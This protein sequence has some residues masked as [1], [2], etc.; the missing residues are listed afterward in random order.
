MKLQ[1]DEDNPKRWIVKDDRDVFIGAIDQI[2]HEEWTATHVAGKKLTRVPFGPH[3]T[4]EAAFEAFKTRLETGPALDKK[5]PKCG[6]T[7]KHTGSTPGG[8]YKP[9]DKF[10]TSGGPHHY[11]CPNGHGH[12]MYSGGKLIEV[13]S[14]TVT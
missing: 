14:S 11:E 13:G 12:F 1:V 5:C 10:K 2:G 3:K 9:G 4:R 8:A 7:L 6:D